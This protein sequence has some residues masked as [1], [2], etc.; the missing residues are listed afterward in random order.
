MNDAKNATKNNLDQIKS[1]LAK[2]RKEWAAAVKKVN[3]LPEGDRAADAGPG[4]LEGPEKLLANI[5]KSV[6]DLGLNLGKAAR[7]VSVTGTFG[8]S[9]LGLLGRGTMFDRIAIATEATA[10]NTKPIK[11]GLGLTFK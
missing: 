6:A 4:T 10:K 1:D 5:R 7:G 11:N 9:A 2:A 8:S 3:A